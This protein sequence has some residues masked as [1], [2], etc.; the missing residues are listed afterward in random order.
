MIRYSAKCLVGSAYCVRNIVWRHFAI[1]EAWHHFIL[2]TQDYDEFCKKH[3]GKFIHHVPNTRRRA[4]IVGSGVLAK[5]IQTAR[6]IFGDLSV[7]W[8][9]TEGARCV[10]DCEKC[11]GHTNCSNASGVPEKCNSDRVP[12]QD[13]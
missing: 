6:G 8:T 1:D 12:V 9:G 2:F 7:N 3:F 5:T 10:S 11:S 4:H 13:A